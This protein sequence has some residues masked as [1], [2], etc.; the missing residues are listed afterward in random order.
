MALE[1]FGSRL[2]AVRQDRGYTQ[3]QLAAALGV[4]EQAVSKWEREIT[5]GKKIAARG[6]VNLPA[7]FVNDKL[8]LQGQ[9]VSKDKARELLLSILSATSSN[10]L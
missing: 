4:T 9:G 3:K 2:K 10:A 8:I 6:L 7:V 1:G 5:D